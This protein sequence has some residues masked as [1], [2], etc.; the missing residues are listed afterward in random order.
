VAKV[1]L[2]PQQFEFVFYDADQIT[3][4]AERIARA[5]GLEGEIHLEVDESSPLGR[6]AV[7]SLDPIDLW[8]QGGAFEDSRHPRCLS[9]RSLD[10]ALGRLMFRVKDRLDPGFADAPGE[11]KLSLQQRNVWDTY[12]LGRLAR[13][14]Y[15][16]AKPRWLYHFRTRHGFT[17]V[18]D[19]AFE[20]I[21]AAD[22]LRWADLEAALTEAAEARAA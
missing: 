9:E 1:V 19:A 12:C 10:E 6:L 3:A 20:R 18:A 11:D 17:D 16:V 4:E 8:V 14:G 22:G 21:W 15:E 13:A 5:A 2:T 7:R